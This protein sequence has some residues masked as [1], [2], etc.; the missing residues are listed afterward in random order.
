METEA[1][2][3]TLLILTIN[4]IKSSM[5]ADTVA[6]LLS[7]LASLTCAISFS[8]AHCNAKVCLLYGQMFEFK[9]RVVPGPSFI[10][11][12][13]LMSMYG[14]AVI[15]LWFFVKIFQNASKFR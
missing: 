1:D 5:Q 12:F 2:L 15:C 3:Q 14:A 8:I 6:F 7:F 13:N 11:Q 10:C 4:N 9:R